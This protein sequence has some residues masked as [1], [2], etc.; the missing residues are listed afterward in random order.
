M[1]DPIKLPK[2][3][4]AFC[5]SCLQN[6]QSVAHPNNPSLLGN[7]S[8]KPLVCPACREG[9]PDIVQSIIDAAMLYG[10]R[11]NNP[12]LTKDEQ[13]HYAGLAL[14]ELAKFDQGATMDPNRKL[15]TLFTKAEML[16]NHFDRPAEALK[17]LEELEAIHEEGTKNRSEV[18]RLMDAGKK[19]AI[20]ERYEEANAIRL[21]VEEKRGLNFAML[22]DNLFDLHLNMAECKASMGDYDGALEIY[23]ASYKEMSLECMRDHQRK[24]YMGMSKCMYHLGKYKKAISLG[25]RAIGYER[26]F[27]QIHKYMALSQMA[28]GDTQA[29]LRTLS[30]AVCYEA[31][32]NEA[33]RT[34]VE[35]MLEDTKKKAAS[36]TGG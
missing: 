25:E 9:A 12:Y 21:K 1:V 3:K 4:H 31:P 11:S 7:P 22:G 23:D 36:M 35:N 28:I 34:I 24:M 27:P 26:T 33:N 20:E 32:W 15:Q 6:W 14:K 2:C 10:A 17:A 8:P 5:F 16:H 19:A 29:A 30:R 18:D 13:K